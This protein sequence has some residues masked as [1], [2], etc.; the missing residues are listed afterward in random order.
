MST[1]VTYDN[2]VIGGGNNNSFS[3]SITIGSNLNTIL[4]VGIY[5]TNIGTTAPD[6]VFVG[7][8][9]MGLFTNSPGPVGTFGEMY[10][11]V[12]QNP[13][14]GSQTISFTTGTDTTAK[15]F[16]VY[17][18]YNVKGVDTFSMTQGGYSGGSIDGSLTGTVNNTLMW[19]CVAA[20]DG[21]GHTPS[22]TETGSNHIQFESFSNAAM[23]GGDYGVL[24]TPTSETASIGTNPGAGTGCVFLLSLEGSQL[25]S[26][27]PT[28]GSYSLAGRTITPTL[29]HVYNLITAV[30][31]YTLTGINSTL[32]FTPYKWKSV[33]KP[34]V[35]SWTDVPKATVPSSTT[36]TG[37]Q[38]VGLLLA[39]TQTISSASSGWKNVL[40]ASLPNSWTD[41]P[42]GN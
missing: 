6:S 36:V 19:A 31:R 2:S 23:Q 34:S 9:Q 8:T 14:S 17:S 1:V 20:R 32:T 13:P 15:F 27:S 40:K 3:F 29:G 25:Y 10:I 18:Y 21:T 26:M 37:G 38:P 35:S 33:A 39:I 4:L 41:V 11:Y 22:G 5:I 16:C 42:K 24:A 28:T 12:L 30:G 7:G